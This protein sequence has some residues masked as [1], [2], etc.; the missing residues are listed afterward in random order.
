MIIRP[1]RHRDRE[2]IKQITAEAFA[3]VSIDQSIQ[4]KLGTVAG[5]SWQWHKARY[6]DHDVEAAGAMVLVAEDEQSGEIVGYITMR[7]DRE[8]SVGLIPN[9]SV[10]AGLRG[11]GIGRKL[12]ERALEAFRDA[13]LEI[14]RIETL[15]QNAIGGHLY[16]SCGFQ[17]VARQVHYA[18]RLRAPDGA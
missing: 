4:Q 6:I 13:G 12:I 15:E 7:M 17:E 11:Q 3:G 10:R 1:Y 16:P 5:R 18:M 14:V 2:T 8:A 9:M